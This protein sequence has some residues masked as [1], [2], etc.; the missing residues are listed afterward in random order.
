MAKKSSIAKQKRRELIVKRAWDKRSDLRR[1]SKDMSLSE[2]ERELARLKL[3]K[4]PRDT[5]Y[6]RL[7]NRCALTGRSRG[8]SRKFRLSRNCFREMAL[9]GSI[10][11]ITKA[12][13]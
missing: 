1:I 8:Y 2:E 7:R 4:M 10:P 9:E 6:I 11:G 12:S 5:C 3:N 13:W